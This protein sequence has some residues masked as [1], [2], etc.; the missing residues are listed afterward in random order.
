MGSTRRAVDFDTSR[1][2]PAARCATRRSRGSAVSCSSRGSGRGRPTRSSARRASGRSRRRDPAGP[3]SSCPSSSPTS[4]AR[5]GW[6][7]ASGLAERVG[8][9]AFSGIL[10]AFYGHAVAAIDA[11]NGIVDKFVGD[12]AIGLFVP[13]LTGPDFVDRALRRR[14]RAARGRRRSRREPHRPDPGRGRDPH[15]C[16][17]GRDR[18]PGRPDPRL[19]RARRPGEHDRPARGAGGCRR[20]PRVGRDG[21]SRPWRRLALPNGALS[22]F[23]AAARRSRS[24]RCGSGPLPHR[25]RHPVRARE[26]R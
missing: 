25:D 5:R 21:R 14:A 3:R 19:H 13:G 4:A 26:D 2:L 9:A 22:T 18:R 10:Q 6:R 1:A 23:A 8:P 12:E 7:S 11:A 17:L 24:T 15:R 20:A 16:R